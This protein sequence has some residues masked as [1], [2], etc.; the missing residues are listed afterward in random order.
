MANRFSAISIK[1]RGLPRAKAI[2]E[3]YVTLFFAAISVFPWRKGAQQ[4]GPLLLNL[5]PRGIKGTKTT[6]FIN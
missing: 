2:I 3:N 4:F 5:T 1:A 6:T